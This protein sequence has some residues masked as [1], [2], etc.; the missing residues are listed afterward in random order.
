MK[1]TVKQKVLCIMAV[2]TAALLFLTA[3]PPGGSSGGDIID[4]SGLLA[5]RIYRIQNWA[6]NTHSGHSNYLSEAANGRLGT[7][8]QDGPNNLW[9]VMTGDDGRKALKNYTTGNYINVK[10]LTAAWDTEPFVS[11]FEDLPSFFWGYDETESG[12]NITGADGFLTIHT[13]ADEPDR[14]FTVN[15]RN[16]G[17]GTSPAWDAAKWSFWVA[18]DL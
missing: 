15:Y 8:S 17:T 11:S 12:T 18:D 3:C 6:D 13:A 7:T 1:K 2:L 10:G 14:A 4:D 16:E 9:Y 5:G